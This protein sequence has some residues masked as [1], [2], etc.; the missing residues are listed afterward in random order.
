MRLIAL[1]TLFLSSLA[2]ARPSL[3][4]RQS[5][6]S[7]LQNGID[8]I[9]LNNQF[10]SLNACTSGSACID[11]QLAQ[12]V[13]GNYVLSPCSSGLICAVLP[14]VN[15][16]GTSVTCMAQ[17]DLKTR[18]AATGASNG[19]NPVHSTVTPSPTKS[20]IATPTASSGS[21]ST[22]SSS[23]QTSL[24]L[25]SS[26][27]AKNFS[28]NGLDTCTSEAGEVASLT[29]TNNFI[30]WCATLPDLPITNGQQL[31]NGSCNPAPMGAIPSTSNIPSVKFVTPANL[32][33]VPPNT[34]FEIALAVRHFGTGCHW[35]HSGTCARRYRGSRITHADHSHRSNQVCILRGAEQ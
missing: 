31:K 21:G 1:S 13:N 4:Q 9:N 10:M 7:Q 11:G 16:L 30:N 5:G 3:R 15:S 32:A 14:S 34:T 33:V 23:A 18:M 35:S 24:T 20:P 26:V 22:N 2:S 29:S 6:S 27:I 25:V 19:T 12:C 28:Q 17:T 8:A